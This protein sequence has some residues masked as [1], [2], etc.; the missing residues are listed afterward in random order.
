VKSVTTYTDR[1][2][3]RLAITTLLSLLG[4]VVLLVFFGDK[5][6]QFQTAL[7]S[8]VVTALVSGKGISFSWYY[9][10][11]PDKLPHDPPPPAPPPT[12]ETP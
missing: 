7:L 5:L 10:G 3:W 2:R 12:G 11:I 8:V 1:A 4:V 9:D 6:N